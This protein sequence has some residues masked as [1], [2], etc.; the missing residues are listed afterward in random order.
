MFCCSLL[1]STEKKEKRKTIPS[2]TQSST[3]T[4]NILLSTGV[5]S[6]TS[7][8]HFFFNNITF[9]APAAPSLLDATLT[10]GALP[11][12]APPGTAGYNV[13]DLK[14]GDVVDLVVYNTDTGVHPLHLHGQSFWVMAQGAQNSGPFDPGSGGADGDLL[15]EVPSRPGPPSGGPGRKRRAAAAAAATSAP[16]KRKEEEKEE[17]RR[18]RPSRALSRASASVAMRGVNETT[19]WTR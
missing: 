12:N 16:P 4:V 11:P 3:K 19:S 7:P 13:L 18:R 2:P 1:F 8:Q 15:T 10:A 9:S 14:F 5:L 6:S 17:A